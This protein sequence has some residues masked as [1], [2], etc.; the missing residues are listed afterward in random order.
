MTTISLVPEVAN[1]VS[2]NVAV[3]VVGFTTVTE[4]AGTPPNVTVA[5]ET[6]FSPVMVTVV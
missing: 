3:I 5:P 1:A 2:G 6:K 4:L